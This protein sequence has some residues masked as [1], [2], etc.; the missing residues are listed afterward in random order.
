[1]A[2]NIEKRRWPWIAGGAVLAVALVLVACEAA[3]WPFLVG[4]L[5]RWSAQALD[6]RIEIGREGADRRARLGLLGGVRVAAPSLEIGAPAW[7]DQPHMARAENVDLRLRYLD[8][9]RAWRSQPLRIASLRVG[10]IDAVLERREDGRAS[11]QFGAPKQEPQPA[12][13]LPSFGELRVEQ[14][15]LIY[16]DAIAAADL[17]ARFSLTEHGTGDR[18]PGV[19][20]ATPSGSASGSASASVSGSAGGSGGSADRVAAGPSGLQL[21]A[22]GTYRKLPLHVRLVTSSALSLAGSTGETAAQPVLLDAKIGRARITFRGTTAN[23]LH[24]AEL[25]GAFSVAGPSLAAVGDPVGVTL[26]TTGPFETEGLLTKEGDL[27]K[28][29]IGHA[30]I[31]QSRLA[32]SFTYDRRPAVPLLA[33]RLT[34]PRLLLKDL[35]PAVGTTPRAERAAANAA[36]RERER[37]RERRAAADARVLPDRR[38]DLPSLRAMN[39]N[40]LVDIAHADLGTPLLEPLEPLR[41]HLRV[42]A[43][44]L[45]LADVEARTAQGRLVGALALDG[46]QPTARWTADVRLLGVQLERWLHQARKD[47]PPYV[48]GRLDGRVQVAGAGRSTAEILSSLNGDI[49]FHIRNGTLSH[50]AIE[51]AGLDVAQALGMIVKGDESLPILCNAVDLKVEKG[52]ARPRVFVIDTRDSTVW[53]DGSVSLA[54]ETLDLKAV[55]SPKDFSPLTARA[56]VHVDGTFAQPRVSVE[57]SKVGAKVGAAVLLSL[58]N[59]LAAV[60][61]FI[62]PGADDDAKRE[63]AQC[64]S[65]AQRGDAAR[66]GPEHRP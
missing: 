57:A 55:V 13:R 39:A 31:G 56:P 21:R 1:M 37:E 22:E 3:G 24:L 5:Q 33:G 54:Q 52:V 23:P 19:A 66:G 44:V 60:I 49:R 16:R 10:S 29:V 38:F 46:R 25:R 20:T 62:D 4:P 42:D 36:A 7:S 48:T 18:R 40:V 58:I 45:T 47:A 34:G 11:W 8:L 64:R 30:T 43:G 35:G 12:A 14:G 9:W 15:R 27:W 65:L 41:A 6:R 28:A 51:A 32:G 50:L 26:P 61:P 17:D 63:A 2:W 53:V 59:P